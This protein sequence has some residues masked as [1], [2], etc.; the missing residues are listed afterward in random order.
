MSYIF[1]ISKLFVLHSQLMELYT[2]GVSINS[3][4]GFVESSI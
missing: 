2:F 1:A 3:G 4:L